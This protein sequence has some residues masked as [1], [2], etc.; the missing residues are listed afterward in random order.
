MPARTD[1]WMT[2]AL[3]IPGPFATVAIVTEIVAP[4]LLFLGFGGRIAAAGLGILLAV[5][6]TTHASNGFFMN[7]VGAQAGEGFEYH[8]L[9]IA[10]ATVIVAKGSGALSIDRT[11]TRSDA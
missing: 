2:R 1:G 8:L 10:V 3:G 4:C 5:A 6:A 7:W 9:G 11:L